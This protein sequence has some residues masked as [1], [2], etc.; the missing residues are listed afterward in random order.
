MIDESILTYEQILFFQI[1]TETIS[2]AFF[3]KN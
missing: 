1:D 2:K 3:Y